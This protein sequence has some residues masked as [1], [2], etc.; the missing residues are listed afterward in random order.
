MTDAPQFRVVVLELFERP[1]RLAIREGMLAI[2]SLQC[3]GFASAAM[4]EW[5]AMHG[6]PAP[7]LR[8]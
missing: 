7:G 5:S 1:V 6:G 2:G 3:P 4:P 8:A